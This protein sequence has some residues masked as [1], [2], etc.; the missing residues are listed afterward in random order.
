MH[1]TSYAYYSKGKQQA[2][3]S[4]L[5]AANNTP[6]TPRRLALLRPA[7]YRNYTYRVSAPPES[8]HVRRFSPPRRFSPFARRG[9]GVGS[10]TPRGNSC[11]LHGQECGE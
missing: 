8:K 5:A 10:S 6:P 7:R 3:Y 2:S 1:T 11:A 9:D 4:K